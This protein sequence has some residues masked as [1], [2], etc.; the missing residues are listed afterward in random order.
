AQLPAA[1]AFI[2]ELR[3]DGVNVI[4][5]SNRIID[6][7]RPDL[8]LFAVAPR[9]ADWK[10]SSGVALARTDAFVIRDV[11]E[12]E[13]Y[14]AVQALAAKGRSGFAPGHGDETTRLLAWLAVR[15]P[16]TSPWREHAE[17]H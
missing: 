1:A 12:A 10:A 15:L 4:V 3:D 8:V 13:A 16:A 11:S 6:F 14:E 9:I 7:I 2:G 17:V 5:E